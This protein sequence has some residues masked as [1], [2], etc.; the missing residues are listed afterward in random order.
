[1]KS[2]LR[3]LSTP[4]SNDYRIYAD[5]KDLRE[6]DAFGPWV[7]P[8]KVHDDMPPRFRA[9]Y[10]EL[11]SSTFLLKVPVN[12]ERSAMRPGMDLYR[13]ILAVYPERIIVLDW[14]GSSV[15]R[16]DIAMDTI[17]AV[18]MSSDLLPSELLLYI[19]DGGVVR[20]E[21]N[22]VSS[23][24]I[25]KVVDFLR[26]R[27]MA[28]RTSPSRSVTNALDRSDSEIRDHFYHGMWAMRSRRVPN[29]RILHWEPPGISCRKYAGWGR[30][31]LG[32]LV[33]AEGDDLVVISRGPFTRSWRETVYSTADLYIP[34]AAVQTAEL[35]QKPSGRR[36]FIP[37]VRLAL[38]GHVFELEL[39]AP[40]R[41][42]HELLASISSGGL[43]PSD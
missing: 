11:Q 34:W 31:S 30:S 38:T 37:T 14:N 16:R 17:Q 15:L 20:L 35:I 4:L 39:F 25:E 36:R 18:R 21:Y 12:A 22:A 6:Y 43:L 9:W 13:S 1:M 19:A 33:L 42:I 5:P 41:Q 23:H 8:I 3:G 10:E 24:E 7:Y 29:V 2:F 40:V 26:Q 32:C 28:S 27:M